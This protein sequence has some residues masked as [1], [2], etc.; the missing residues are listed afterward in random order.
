VVWERGGLRQ[1]SLDHVDG[2]HRT[3]HGRCLSPG[4]SA[5]QGHDT[6]LGRAA[7]AR[8]DAEGS[9]NDADRAAD[10]EA[11]RLA[12]RDCALNPCR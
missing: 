3:E 6:P 10:G 12:R 5:A 7:A 8:S 1:H 11:G 2:D 4:D 9:A